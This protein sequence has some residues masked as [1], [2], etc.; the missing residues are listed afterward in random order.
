MGQ[1]ELAEPAHLGLVGRKQPAFG[2]VLGPV[3]REVAVHEGVELRVLRRLAVAVVVTALGDELPHAALALEGVRLD[4]HARVRR[5]LGPAPLGV[6]DA[7]QRDHPVTVQVIRPVLPGAPVAIV[8]D[9]VTT[10]DALVTRRREVTLGRVGVRARN[11]VERG[12]VEQRRDA[13]VGPVAFGQPPRRGQRDVARV[14]QGAV[15]VGDDQHRGAALHPLAGGEPQRFDLESGARL[16]DV[17]QADVLGM[18]AGEAGHRLA[19]PARFEERSRVRAG[20]RRGV[21]GERVRQRRER[22][23]E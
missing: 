10:R 20:T 14:D 6:G 11:D 17:E 13:L 21:L 12:G 3:V 4:E 9:A 8:V 16:A 1:N 2:M 18:L 7:H 23:E 19:Q 22:Q 5:V 15:D